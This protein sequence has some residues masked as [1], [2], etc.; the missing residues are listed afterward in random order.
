MLDLI[1]N[2]FQDEDI[3]RLRAERRQQDAQSDELQKRG[4]LNACQSC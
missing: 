4:Q 2:L 3:D 1:W